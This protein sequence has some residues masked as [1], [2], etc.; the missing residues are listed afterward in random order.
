MKICV[1]GVPGIPEGKH[2]IKDPRLDQAHELVEAKKKTYAQV[3]VVGEQ[4]AIDADVI[5]VSRDRL[6]DLLLKDL[7]FI[8]TRLSREPSAAE[9]EVLVK[10]QT[11]LE[12]ERT[13]ASAGLSEEDWQALTGHGFLTSKPVIMANPDELDD[14]DALMVRTFKGSG[15]ICFL[16]VGG[17]ENRAWPIRQGLTAAEAA[18]SIHTDLQKGFIRAEVIDFDDLLAAGGEKGA[19]HAG[20]QRLEMKAYVV[21]DYDVMNIR[22]NK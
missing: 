4:G 14:P 17:P 15:Y 5:L 1:I 19:K 9:R 6:I 20:K 10:L 12:S 18:G 3:D 11:H 7:E 8:E 22:A 21:R 16:T 2:N 13:V